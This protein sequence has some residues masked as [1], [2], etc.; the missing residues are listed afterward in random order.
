ME[1]HEITQESG[2]TKWSS[3]STTKA[4]FLTLAM[5]T[6]SILSIIGVIVI[7]LQIGK[8]NSFEAT[9]ERGSV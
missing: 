8:S 4:K 5:G 3:S 6:G 2:T 9:E 1:W 7:S